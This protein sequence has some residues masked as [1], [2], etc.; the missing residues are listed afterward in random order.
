MSIYSSGRKPG[1]YMG[2][3]A[4]SAVLLA[5]VLG[6]PAAAGAE[7]LAQRISPDYVPTVESI[8]SGGDPFAWSASPTSLARSGAALPAA[9]DLRDSEAYGN[10]VTP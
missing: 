8:V 6:T 10:A 5:G 2:W 9:F 4:A 1:A 7:T 3:A